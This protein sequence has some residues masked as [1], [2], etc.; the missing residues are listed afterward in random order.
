MDDRRS[1]IVP[2]PPR[3]HAAARPARPERDIP[4]RVRT[5]QMAADLAATL[6]LVWSASPK[7]L[8][9]ILTLSIVLALVPAIAL[10]VGK[11]L[12]DEVARAIAG[13]L[14]SP[15]AAYQ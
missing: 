3:D 2:M 15:A 10:W 5:R 14:Q 11:L 7:L 13:E 4:L 12:L 9:L 6:R 8:A 1:T